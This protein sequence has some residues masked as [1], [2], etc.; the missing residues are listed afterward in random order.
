MIR[1]LTILL[2]IVGCSDTYELHRREWSGLIDMKY[3]SSHRHKNRTLY[4][5]HNNTKYEIDS[6]HV[7]WDIKHKE[8]DKL[9]V[10]QHATCKGYVENNVVDYTPILPFSKN[11]TTW[12]IPNPPPHIYNQ[13]RGEM[14]IVKVFVK[15]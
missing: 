2:L 14:E 4:L 11:E 8:T 13:V 10:S 12:C 3:K 6:I 7:K 15:K 9:I 5:T 1:R